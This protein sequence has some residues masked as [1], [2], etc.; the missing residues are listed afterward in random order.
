MLNFPTPTAETA[1][2]SAGA[3][4]AA[5]Q[6]AWGFA[7]N[8]MRT[9]ANSPAVVEGAWAILGAF[10]KTSFTAAEQQLIALA[11]SVENDCQYCAAAHSLMGKGAGLTDTQLAA[12]RSGQPLV[13]ARLEALRR[14]TTAVVAHRG[15]VP[16]AGVQAFLAAG[17][18][19]TQVLEVVLGVAA[20]TLMNYT[21]HLAAV[22]L[23]D[24][25]QPHAWQP[26]L[27]KAA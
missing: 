4:L 13:D 25:F 14:F 15:F 3:T 16:E 21:D 1:P 7:P 18:A 12:L 11:I 17:F 9:F 5:V 23:D 10:G 27:K 19:Q 24:A 20:K 26:A 8:L 2:G 22:T 6:K